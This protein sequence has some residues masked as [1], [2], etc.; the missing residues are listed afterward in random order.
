MTAIEQS[1]G[2]A[3]AHN[4]TVILFPYGVEPRLVFGDNLVTFDRPERFGDWDT[5]R[6]RRAFMRAFTAA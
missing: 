6:A 3:Y 5:P 4:G 2:I 1:N